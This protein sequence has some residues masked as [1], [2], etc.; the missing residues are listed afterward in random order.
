[1]DMI[2]A[3]RIVNGCIIFKHLLAAFSRHDEHTY[4]LDKIYM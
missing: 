4:E 3:K 1:M 2:Q